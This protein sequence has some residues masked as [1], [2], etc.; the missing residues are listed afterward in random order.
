MAYQ[1]YAI[2]MTSICDTEENFRQLA[3]ALIAV[4]NKTG[5][6]EE[7]QDTVQACWLP[8]QEKS[9]YEALDYDGELIRLE[10]SAGLMS[11]EYVWVY[12]PGIPLI[13]P[14]EIMDSNLIRHMNDLMSAE[15]ILNSSRGK[16]PQF[17]YAKRLQDFGDTLTKG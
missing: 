10:E 13:T 16:M 17:I 11:L 12:P 7:R 14:G 9:I 1:D 15:V 4:D 5:K 6:N 2:A 3:D 8:I